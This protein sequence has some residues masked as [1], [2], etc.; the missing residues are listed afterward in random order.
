MTWIHSTYRSPTSDDPVPIL[1]N[2]DHVRSIR[3]TAGG[4]VRVN[5]ANRMDPLITDEDYAEFI[6]RVSLR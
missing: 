3:R 6:K 1:I 4:K 5:W 2:L